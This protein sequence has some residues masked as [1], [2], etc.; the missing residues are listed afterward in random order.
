MLTAI[1]ARLLPMRSHLRLRRVRPGVQH[2]VGGAVVCLPSGAQ[3][4]RDAG[5]ELHRR[6]G[7]AVRPVEEA[8]GAGQLRPA[9]LP[10]ALAVCLIRNHVRINAT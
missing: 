3:L 4:R 2:G 9:H 1:K 8:R 7:L 10:H 5:E 6:H